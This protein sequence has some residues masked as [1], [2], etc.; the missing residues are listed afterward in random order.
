MST[1]ATLELEELLAAGLSQLGYQPA[2][3]TVARLLRYV[4]EIEL[5][6][7]RLK[8]VAASG[9]RARR[10]PRTRQPRRC[11]R[12]PRRV[13]DGAT[14]RSPD[15]RPRQRRRTA[16]YT[17]CDR[18]PAPPRRSRRALRSTRGLPPQRRRGDEVVE[19]HRARGRRNRV[20]RARRPRGFSGFRTT[21]G[22]APRGDSP[23]SARRRGHLCVQG[24]ITTVREELGAL[25]LSGESAGQ[26]E[27]DRRGMRGADVQV[28]AV[29]VPP[30]CGAAPRLFGTREG[31]GLGNC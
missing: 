9:T 3:D 16:R 27:G 24:G 20:P 26:A 11:G 21:D 14:R 23:R 22:R 18:L 31:A 15:R 8:L 7:P 10:P 28:V 5:W 1:G 17:D 19:R 6:N 29:D 25:G 30:A 2:S 4:A 12:D 13:G